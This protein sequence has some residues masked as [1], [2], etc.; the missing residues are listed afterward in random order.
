M[1]GEAPAYR[2]L[3]SYLTGSEAKELADRIEDGETLGSSLSVIGSARRTRVRELLMAG[4]LGPDRAELSVAV[5]RAVEGAHT[6]PSMITPV[7]TAPDNLAQHGQLTASVHH[8]VS[9]A[10]ESVICSTFNFQRSSTLWKALAD[11]AARSEVHV[12]IYV[13]TAAADSHPASWKPT[14]QQ[15]ADEMRGAIVLRT[16]PA[17]DG[18]I[19]NHA[20]FIAVDHQ[21]LVVT[22][23]N[24][25][26]SAEQHNV[27]L[28]LVIQNPILTQLVEQQMRSLETAVFEVVTSN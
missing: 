7:W 12:R 13:D 21:F 18:Y 26:K 28:G 17:G 15:V 11:T 8:Y 1:I 5:L 6:R 24:F 3:A 25:S 23:A 10:R 22:S 4:G 9:R 2:E 20:K 16:Q 27:E 14:T 19:R